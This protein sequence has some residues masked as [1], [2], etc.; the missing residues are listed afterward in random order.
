MYSPSGS[1]SFL[2]SAAFEV[3]MVTPLSTPSWLTKSSPSVVDQMSNS[4]P[5]TPMRA[6]PF[7]E[8]IEFCEAVVAS[9]GP[10]TPSVFQ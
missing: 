10:V 9:S 7:C 4:E 2:T 8:L 3:W 1:L 6:A 5:Y